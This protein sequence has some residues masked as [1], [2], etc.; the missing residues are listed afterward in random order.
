ML[1]VVVVSGIV[2][3]RA[4]ALTIQSA[5]TDPETPPV[6]V[7]DPTSQEPLK[8]TLQISNDSTSAADIFFWRI[9]LQATALQ[10]SSGTLEFTAVQTADD[11]LFPAPSQPGTLSSLPNSRIVIEDSD[12]SVPLP[13]QTISADSS[14]NIV[15]LLAI[16]SP[17][18]SGPFEIEMLLEGLSSDDGSFWS[19]DI[20]SPSEIP[21]ENQVDQVAPNRSLIVTVVVLSVPEPTSMVL[22]TI[23][24]CLLLQPM[25]SMDLFP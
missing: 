22:L 12:F 5:S 15:H 1:L 3:V 8:L 13:G 14:V 24:F 18:A 25:R 19:S 7:Y 2:A 9:E 6:T 4:D 11:P 17:D 16:A 20:L 21:F 10:N 23:A